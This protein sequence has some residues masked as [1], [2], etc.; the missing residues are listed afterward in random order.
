MPFLPIAAAFTVGLIG[1]VAVGYRSGYS[2]GSLVMG[3]TLVAAMTGLAA[4]VLQF[5]PQRGFVP[6]AVV[7]GVVLGL[8]A[9]AAMQWAEVVGFGTLREPVAIVWP[10]AIVTGLLLSRASGMDAPKMRNRPD[11]DGPRAR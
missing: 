3:A 5:L 2:F 11:L 6:A 4:S 7:A 1:A 9:T 10:V 8:L